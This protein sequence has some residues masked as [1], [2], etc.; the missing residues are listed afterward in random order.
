MTSVTFTVDLDD[1]TLAA[2]DALAATKGNDRAAMLERLV[3]EFLHF[4]AETLEY[5]A[6]FR[7][8]VDKGLREMAEPG[9]EF[10]PHEAVMAEAKALL[11]T[12]L[13]QTKRRAG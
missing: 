7:R 12:Q 8:E 4:E 5:D 13:A 1:E 3:H 11:D 6:W 10:F 9:A 2:F